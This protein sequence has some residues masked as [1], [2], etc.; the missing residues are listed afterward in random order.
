MQHVCIPL[1][2]LDRGF[3]EQQLS[4]AY[5]PTILCLTL[6]Q[7]IKLDRLGKLLIVKMKKQIVILL[8]FLWV[9]QAGAQGLPADT[10]SYLQSGNLDN[11]SL[12]SF[13]MQ[14]GTGGTVSNYSGLNGNG[15]KVSYNFPSSGGWVNLEIPLGS[16]YTRS[17][18]MVFFVYSTSS[19]A[20]LEIKFIDKDGSVFDLRPSLSKY[21]GNWHH[22]T[23]YLINTGYA[24][25]GNS[26]FDTPAKFSL[27]ISASF[28]SSG[29][30]YFDEIG[31]GQAGLP[32]SFM[33][34][35][36]PNRQLAGIGF[37]QRRD[38]SMIPEDPLVLKYLQQLQDLGSQAGLLLPT[39]YGAVQAQ[40]FNNSLAAMAFIT[41]DEKQRAERILDFY[42]HATD[43]SNTNQFK[44]N[45][46][47]NRQARGFFQECDIH[48]LEATGS[49]NRWI[50]DMAW[51][52]IAC[53]NYEKK[54]DST[55]Y[56]YL[57]GLIRDLFMSFY[58]DS[59]TGGYIQHGWAYGDAYLH[60]PEGHHEGNID[61]YVA[62]KLCG[63]DFMA[64]QIKRWLD[65]Q[66][67][68]RTNLPL[69]LYTWRTLA[70]GALGEL[71]PSLLNIAEYDFR[72]RKII[73]VKG[74][75]VMGM[76]SN[77][78]IT[79]QNFW[80]D[81]TGHISC[82][83]Q[84]FG[85]KQRGMFYA[86]QLD[87]LIVARQIGTLTIHGIAYTFNTQGYP[88]I[89]P[90][91]PVLSSSAWYILAKNRVNPFLSE[92]FRDDY[93]DAMQPK[94]NPLFSFKVY[95]N[96]FTT[97]LTIHFQSKSNSGGIVHIYNSGGQMVNTLA[98][99]SAANENNGSLRWDGTDFNGKKVN[100]GLYLLELVIEGHV[101]TKMVILSGR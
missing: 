47:Y 59:S 95:P 99:K 3:L 44:Q 58:K 18:P 52:L 94:K 33:P 82:A 46:F 9:I 15:L 96:P 20:N 39:Y 68:G 71:Y 49:R 75:E 22:V 8:L 88:G 101:E 90:S 51:L 17:N 78:D 7:R 42:L 32:S 28:P 62:L 30:V 26:T 67:T 24:W 69:D 79:I 11:Y 63:E 57:T 37:A 85:D 45:F 2:V 53:K 70:F 23:A 65:S 93:T 43:S 97:A 27:A 56:N 40:T 36:D 35:L 19:L 61:C 29:I 81:G 31:I 16:S 60:E 92:N 91:V 5:Y 48:N 13:S 84:A 83:F 21:S 87:P 4:I 41:K 74:K 100:A 76:Y 50:G 77:P 25:G 54:Y 55:R 38:T 14:S 10:T 80:N 73:P 34:T 98:S 72:Y 6:T 86:N 12:W 1:F 64:H 89:D 66:L